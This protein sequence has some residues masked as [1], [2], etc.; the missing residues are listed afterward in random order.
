MPRCTTHRGV[1]GADH[2]FDIC[3]I[4]FG[5]SSLLTMSCETDKRAPPRETE[6]HAAR[7]HLR[8]ARGNLARQEALV[9]KIETT[10]DFAALER[11]RGLLA[12][13]R[14]A[15]EAAERHVASLEGLGVR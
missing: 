5:S 12:G 1:A 4:L 14:L 11:E 7:R 8:E 10:S 3:R 13:M 6:L 9:A 2:G 15:T